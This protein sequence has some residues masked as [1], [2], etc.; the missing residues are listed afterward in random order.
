MRYQGTEPISKQLTIVI[1]LAVVGFMAF[2]L[3]LSFYRNTLFEQ[4]L[5]N[6][7]NQNDLLRGKITLGYRDLEY[8]RSA[9][10]KDKYAKEN[11]GLMN[12]GEKALVITEEMNVVSFPLTDSGILNAEQQEATYLE[13]LRQMP[14]IEHWKL[15]LFHRKKIEELKRAL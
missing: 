5:L 14:V 15:F 7:Q 11:L 3:A 10:Y 8:Y 13:L 2:G 12:P 4:T 1:G 6:I 9:Q